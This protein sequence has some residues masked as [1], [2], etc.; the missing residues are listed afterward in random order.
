MK[1][2]D[3]VRLLSMFQAV[4]IGDQ[5]KGFFCDVEDFKT[6]IPIIERGTE[7]EEI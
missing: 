4:Y 6:V 3:L 2:N 1:E 5:L 7:N